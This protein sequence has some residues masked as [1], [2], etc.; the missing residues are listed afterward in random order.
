MFCIHFSNF[1]WRYSLTCVW[2]HGWSGWLDPAEGGRGA[3]A[4]REENEQQG[5]LALLFSL[6]SSSSSFLLLHI[7]PFQ[8]LT[9]LTAIPP[10]SLPLPLL[11]FL[12][13]FLHPPSSLPISLLRPRCESP[14]FSLLSLLPP[15]PPSPPLPPSVAPD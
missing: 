11:H 9:F 10:S 8:P 14:H 4:S 5:G 12:L 3:P 13:P 7:P 6:P 2:V 15:P 1:M